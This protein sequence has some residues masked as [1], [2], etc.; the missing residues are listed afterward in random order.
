VL[1]KNCIACHGQ[2][3]TSGLDV[4]ERSTI[5][6]GGAQ[7]GASTSRC[8]GAFASRSGTAASPEGG[9]AKDAPYTVKTRHGDYSFKSARPKIPASGTSWACLKIQSTWCKPTGR[10]VGS[11]W[12]R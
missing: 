5:L 7:H 3:Q 8:S 6:K 9:V 11:S 12:M 4:R 1:A 2:L 10:T